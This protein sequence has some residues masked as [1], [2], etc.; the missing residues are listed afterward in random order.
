LLQ[1]IDIFSELEIKPWCAIAYSELGAL[2]ANTGQTEKALESLK[3][4]E[5][6]MQEMGMDYWLRRTQEVLESVE[7]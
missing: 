1:A 4:A 6:M 5:S 3:K 2:Y 7:G